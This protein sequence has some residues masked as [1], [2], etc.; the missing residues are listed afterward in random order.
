[1][2]QSSDPIPPIRLASKPRASHPNHHLV[3]NNGTWWCQVTFHEG[4]CSKRHR[5]SLR[6]PCVQEARARRDRIFA[7]ISKQ[8]LTS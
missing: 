8:P 4:P 1:M 3:N 7:R 5:F 2:N 6:T